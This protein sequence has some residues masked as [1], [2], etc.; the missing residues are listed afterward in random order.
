MLK[1]EVHGLA[2]RVDPRR[3]LVRH[4][5]AVGVLELLDER[6]EVQGVRLEVVLEVR[7]L[8]DARRIELELV[9]E[10]GADGLEDVFPGHGW[11]GTVDPT[12]HPSAGA[13]RAPPAAASV[14]SVRPTTSSRTPRASRSIALV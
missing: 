8:V 7:A 12:A 5:H 11:S 4:R 13:G 9:G 14:S 10:M 1:H 3:L 2:D 6:V